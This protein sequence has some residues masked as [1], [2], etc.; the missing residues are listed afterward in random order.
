MTRR[1]KGLLARFALEGNRFGNSVVKPKLFEPNRNLE[2]SVF[3]ISGLY[4]AEILDLGVDVARKH[5]T[6]RRLH[7]WGEISQSTVVSQNLRVQHD[8][9]PSRH[10]N[11]VGWPDKRSE[12]KLK[13][14]KL[15]QQ[16]KPIRLSPPA[17]I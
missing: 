14:Q 13:Q 1:A 10:A 12:R 17:E 6:S 16:A 4:Y 11:I 9:Q 7:G 2:L 8:G 15:A 3:D 5:P